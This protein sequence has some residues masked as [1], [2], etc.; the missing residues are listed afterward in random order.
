MAAAQRL[1][2]TVQDD[3]VRE[4]IVDWYTRLK[5]DLPNR[6][7]RAVETEERTGE[8]PGDAPPLPITARKV[9]AMLRLAA[10]SPRLRFS[11]VIEMRDVKRARPLIK[12]SLADIGIAPDDNEAFEAAPSDVAAEEVGL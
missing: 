5:T 8:Y 10:A 11:E 4:A 2:P 3:A 1:Q 7:R 6:Y 9:G 12:R